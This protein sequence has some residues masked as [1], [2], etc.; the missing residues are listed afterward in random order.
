MN[1][2]RK[3]FDLSF[4]FVVGPVNTK[5]RDFGDVVRQAVKGGITFLQVRSK[6]SEGRE[7][8]ALGRIAAGEI[9]K[10]GKQDKIALVIDDRVDVARALM[11]EG[12]KVDGVHLGQSDIPVEAARQILGE[13]AIIGLSARSRDLFDYLKKFKT[14][15]VDYF[16]AG[17][18][19]PSQTKPNCG[20]VDGVVLTRSFDEIRKLKSLS[21]LPVV[22][23][24]SVKAKDLPAL[25]ATGVDGF[26]VV[27]AVS[28]ANNPFEAAKELSEIWNKS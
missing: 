7:L 22:I 9:S 27:S 3:T 6:V 18:L 1:S 10:A 26:F 23:G 14:G 24:G 11:L 28:E 16:G 8:M 12:V 4:Y 5:G 2:L 25:K 20:M 15:I 19:R 17:P 21:P 13:D